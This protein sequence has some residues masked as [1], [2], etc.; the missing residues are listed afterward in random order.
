MPLVVDADRLQFDVLN[1]K[2]TVR[3]GKP[4][5]SPAEIIAA[6]KNTGMT[7]ESWSN[8]ASADGPRTRSRESTAY[9]PDGPLG[10]TGIC[11][12]GTPCLVGGWIGNALGSEGM[13]LNTPVPIPAIVLYVAGI[14][15]GVWY[16]APRALH[17]V[18]RLTP[19]MNLLMFIAV[20]GAALIGEWFEAVTVSFL[21]S[22]S[23]L[24]ESWSVGRA[25]RAIA[26]LMDLAPVKARIRNEQGTEDEVSPEQV[27]VGQL[28]YVRP[29]EKIPVG[30]QG[31]K[32]REQRQSSSPSREKACR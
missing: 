28:F 21:F 1:R 13:G 5:V 15:A 18:K 2:L 17:S 26:A 7:A 8:E 30:R 11:G 3:R 6:V 14:V 4:R 20:C 9:D 27:A 19:D 23:L 29:G 10:C 16:V 22:V 24:L 25:R 12:L 32:W 31:E